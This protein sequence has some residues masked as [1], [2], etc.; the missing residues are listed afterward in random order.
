MSVAIQ[1]PDIASVRLH[2]PS[3]L[4]Q[5]VY[6]FPFIFLYPLYFYTYYVRYE[7]WIKSEEWTF[8]Y[9]VALFSSHALAYLGTRWNIGFKAWATT[10]KVSE[11]ASTDYEE[12]ITR[13]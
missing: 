11:R 2:A 5:H 4:W 10:R 13:Y 8:V 9:S 3:P 7:D 12:T 1:S 6:V